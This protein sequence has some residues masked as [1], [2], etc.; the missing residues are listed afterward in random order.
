MSAN[1]TDHS[2]GNPSGLKNSNLIDGAKIVCFARNRKSAAA[3]T[4][5]NEVLNGTPNFTK[6]H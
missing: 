2:G 4:T 6:T 3:I 5:V 1:E